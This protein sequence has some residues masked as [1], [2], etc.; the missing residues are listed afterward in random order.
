MNKN[1]ILEIKSR[2]ANVT[3]GEWERANKSVRVKGTQET[4][5]WG[6]AA[7]N[8]WSGGICNCLGTGYSGNKNHPINVQACHNAEFITH[9]PSD[10]AFLLERYEKQREEL[11]LLWAKEAR[12]S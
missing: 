9:A 2:L 12:R 3:A 7:P 5:S 8:G 10:V 11:R 4:Y 6:K 1:R